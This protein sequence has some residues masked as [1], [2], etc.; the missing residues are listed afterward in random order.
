MSSTADTSVITR[1]LID[2]A[3]TY[4]E[5]SNLVDRLMEEGKTT[6]GHTDEQ[7]LHYSTMNQHRMKRL[8][9]TVKLDEELEQRLQ[10]VATPMIWLVL[11]EGWCGDA[12]QNLPVIKKMADTN[13]AIDLRI[14]LREENLDVMD[15]YLT[16]GGRSIPKLVALNAD[17]LEELGTWGP[18][19]EPAQ[20]LY[21]EGKSEEGRTKKEIAKE[22]Q[23]WYSKDKGKTVQEE[24][25]PL[26]EQW[27]NQ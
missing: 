6:S 1:E 23:K 14:I 25:R 22:I 18:R 9:K 24:L 19:P 5:Y 20:Q 27:D 17:T 3:M 11:S 26:I 13:D 21:E 15:Q 8:D 16:N 12:A 7:M 4:E 10:D 2:N